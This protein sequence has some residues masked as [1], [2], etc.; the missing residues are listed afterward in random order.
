MKRVMV[1]NKKETEP[2]RPS[3]DRTKENLCV[4][5]MTIIKA[6]SRL[7]QA[8]REL[9]EKGTVPAGVRDP[10]PYCVRATSTVVPDN[11]NW[12]EG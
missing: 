12:V 7:L 4:G 11:I 3:I 6:R 9:R 5:D 10:S 8:A 2:I 1:A